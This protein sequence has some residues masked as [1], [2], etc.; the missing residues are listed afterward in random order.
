MCECVLT[1]GLKPS[2]LLCPWDFPGKNIG[3]GCHF[4]LQGIFPTQ[5][6]NLRLLCLLHWQAC[7]LPLSHLG[8]QNISANYILSKGR[9]S[10]TLNWLK[11]PYSARSLPLPFPHSDPYQSNSSA[12]SSSRNTHE[13]GTTASTLVKFPPGG[14]TVCKLHKD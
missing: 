1:Y 6:S 9:H 13:S 7:S 12:L 4:L 2:R 11:G 8:L 10:S 3:V 14:C 5:G